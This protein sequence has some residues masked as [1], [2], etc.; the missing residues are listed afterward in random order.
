MR[1]HILVVFVCDKEHPKF[2]PKNKQLKLIVFHLF[3]AL[4]LPLTVLVY[5][6]LEVV[7]PVRNRTES[8]LPASTLVRLL[9]L[10]RLESTNRALFVETS[11]R[12][13]ITALPLAKDAR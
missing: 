2:C 12:V 11:H 9:R 6:P 13:I 1:N 3:F 4:Q 10:P 7:I 5:L 8:I